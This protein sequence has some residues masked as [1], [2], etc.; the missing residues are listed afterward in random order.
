M[1]SLSL[2][3]VQ[4]DESPHSAAHFGWRVLKIQPSSGPLFS[5]VFKTPLFKIGDPFNGLQWP[6]QTPNTSPTSLDPH[7]QELQ[8]NNANVSGPTPPIQCTTLVV[9]GTEPQ[10][11][12][13]GLDVGLR[14]ESLLAR[15]RISFR[16]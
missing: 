4:N 15:S 11:G 16:P 2:S 10:A 13:F 3:N 14:L 6:A 5:I 7:M 12:D 8:Q 1:L 9:L